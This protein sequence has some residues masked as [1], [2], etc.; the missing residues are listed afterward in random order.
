MRIDRP[1]LYGMKLRLCSHPSVGGVTVSMVAFQAV[2]PG[3]TPGRRTLFF[4]PLSFWSHCTLLRARVCVMWMILGSSKHSLNERLHRRFDGDKLSD[5][6]RR[7][8]G[9]VTVSMVAFQ[10]VDPGSTPGR[11]TLFLMISFWPL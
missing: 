6:A 7:S 4:L 11:R 5:P 1:T 8:V 2:D 10:A 3:S 9:G